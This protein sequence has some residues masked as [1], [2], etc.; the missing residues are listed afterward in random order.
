[1]KKFSALLLSVLCMTPFLANARPLRQV[2]DTTSRQAAISRAI[3]QQ[4]ND[5]NKQ[6]QASSDDSFAQAQQALNQLIQQNK[7][8]VSLSWEDF[9]EKK[10]ASPTTRAARAARNRGRTN[11]GVFRFECFV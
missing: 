3:F 1:M 4:Q 11:P 7:E 8:T 5:Y 9:I 2:S 10:Q 6:K